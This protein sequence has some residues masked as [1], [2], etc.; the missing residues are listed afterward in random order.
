MKKIW[1]RGL[2]LLPII[3]T[4]SA[5]VAAVVVAG[6]AAGGLVINDSRSFKQMNTDATIR[7]QAELQIASR[8]AFKNSKIS[9][10]S[11]NQM[12]LLVGQTPKAS[13]R[14][15]AEKLLLADTNVK[16][17]YN[18]ITIA[19][20]LPL[21]VQGKDTWITSSVKAKMLTRSG[22]QSGS[23]NV[24]SEDGVVYLMGRVTHD[25]ANL[26]VDVAR[27]IDGVKRVVKIFQYTD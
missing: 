4:L 6:V 3:G 9:I 2:F 16:R 11:Y 17:V 25:Q 1:L 19:K 10:A 15:T 7:R 12:V 22:L 24:I 8:P 21:S 13:L 18:E 23:F 26:A 5:C 14:V 27:R 20:P